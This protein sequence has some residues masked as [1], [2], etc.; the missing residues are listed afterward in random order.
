MIRRNLF[1]LSWFLFIIS[2]VTSC[3]KNVGSSKS[4]ERAGDIAAGMIPG[5]G[6]SNPQA[7][8]L[9]AGEW[10]DFEN[11]N[12]WQTLLT[13][14]TFNQ[15]QVKWGFNCKEKWEFV[16]KDVNQVAVPDA[17]VA[18]KN[19]GNTLWEGKT[20]KFGI[21]N[22]IPAIFSVTPLSNL[23]YTVSYNSQYYKTGNVDA[24]IRSI[25][26]SLPVA[27]STTNSVDI[28]FVVD[29]TGS[30]SDEITYLKNEL[31]DVLNRVDNQLQGTLRYS[32]IFY[33]DFN[34]QYLTRVQGFSSNKSDIVDFVKAQTAGGGGDWPEAV[35]EALKEAVQ[36]T[37]SGNAK[38]R[39]LFLIADAPVHE[40]AQKLQLLRHQIQ[41]AA[42]KG[43]I[44][45]P[46]SA[47]G[48]DK[49]TEFLFRF[50][51][52]ATNGTY[53]FLT[54]DSGIGESHVTP[55]V[56]NYQVEY[57]NNLMVRLILKYGGN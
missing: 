33:R 29:A 52:Q 37:W 30:M 25:N 24:L 45:I 56:G 34:D 1:R 57:L 43:I 23:T 46:V 18:V 9:T 27:A 51:A 41:L 48:I 12:F 39:I 7:G 5:P 17:I 50:M 19:N 8:V 47:S 3:T 38:A 36:Q 42:A 22:M 26:V 44:I 21:V 53:A 49:A 28:M 13:N 40:D 35:E 6:G 15:F 16:V 31:L 54:N 14:D 4:S 2:I 32:S 10:N 11:W 20:N 55:T